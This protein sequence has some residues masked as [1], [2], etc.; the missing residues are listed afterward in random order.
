MGE[1]AGGVGHATSDDPARIAEEIE[2][3][4]AEMSGT[5]D[6]IQ[7]RLDPDRLSQQAIDT[8]TEVTGQAVH[9]A[10]EVTTQ[11]RDAAKEVVTYTI[12]EA[13]AAVY[14]LTGHARE[15]VR[16]ST[17][18]RVEQ[19]ALS[20]RDSMQAAQ[21][22]L[23]TTI[24]RNP[25]P[26]ALAAIGIGWLWTHRTSAPSQGGYADRYGMAAAGDYGF[27]A[28]SGGYRAYGEQASAGGAIQDIGSQ[29]RQVADQVMGQVQE[30]AGQVPAM[31][32]G[33]QQQAQ[34]FWQMLEEN[35][36]AVGALGVALGGFAGLMIPETRQE[37]QLMGETRDRVLGSVQGV[38]G[39]TAEKV[40]QVASEA[41]R[42]AVDEASAQGIIP[43][44]R[45]SRSSP[46]A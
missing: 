7:H 46:M 13:K 45:E 31:A 18:G 19:M 16:A 1:R 34:G 3:T 27:D 41:A 44:E 23:W 2:Q 10:T 42:T 30:R 39:Q 36:V 35:P 43:Q 12:D 20:T 33:V 11:A 9:A 26:A 40:Q 24:K 38:V 17:V 29:T 28:S 37:H 15:A 14:E 6:A 32:S 25:I 22:D 21:G 5:I 4:R 8:A